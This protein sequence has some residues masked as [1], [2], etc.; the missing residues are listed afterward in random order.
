M[1]E[2]DYESLPTNNLWQH[3]LAGAMAGMMEHC[4]MYP[5]DCVKVMADACTVHKFKSR[6]S[7]ICTC[8]QPAV[9]CT[10]GVGHIFYICGNGSFQEWIVQCNNYTCNWILIRLF[11]VD[12]ASP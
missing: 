5:V 11:V 7:S 2:V 4:C 10:V 9:V 6:A 1:G 12:N 3:L 8:I